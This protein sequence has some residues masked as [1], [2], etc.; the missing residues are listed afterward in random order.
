MQLWRGAP[1]WGSLL[2]AVTALAICLNRTILYADIMR[3][4]LKDPGPLPDRP[5]RAAAGRPAFAV[6]A[7]G[8][9]G[10]KDPCGAGPGRRGLHG[11]P[12]GLQPG[13][14]GAG[15][16]RGLFHCAGD[17]ALDCCPAA[18]RRMAGRPCMAR[19]GPPRQL[20]LPVLHH[21]RVQHGG[22]DLPF[23]AERRPVRAQQAGMDLYPPCRRGLYPFSGPPSG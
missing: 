15:D 14:A 10:Q 8:R 6:A 17:A 9:P 3:N 22:H 19:Q 16:R 20:V 5:A 7:P 12:A 1:E 13:G 4:T 18:G 23:G 2:L 21:R 11:R